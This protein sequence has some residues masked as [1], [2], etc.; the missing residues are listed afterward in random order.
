MKIIRVSN[1]ETSLI[2]IGLTR[3]LLFI[4]AVILFRFELVFPALLCILLLMIS[5]V[6]KWWSKKGLNKLIVSSFFIPKRIFAGDN[7]AFKVA[8][9][10]DKFLPAI[11]NWKIELPDCIKGQ[12]GVLNKDKNFLSFSAILRWYEKKEKT[13]NLEVS[14]RGYYQLNKFR[15]VSSDLIGISDYEALIEEDTSLIVYPPVFPISNYGIK[16][17]D[18]IGERMDNRYILPDPIMIMGLREYNSDMP[19]YL[20]DWKA[21]A[22]RDVFMA[23]LIEPSANY[24]ICVT[25]DVEG[26]VGLEDGEEIF[27]RALSI[28][29]SIAVW[30]DE[31]KIPIGLFINITQKGFPGPIVVPVNS[32]NSHMLLLLEKLARA[33][34]QLLGSWQDLLHLSKQE[35]PW[36]TTLIVIRADYV[37]MPD[38]VVI[39]A[40]P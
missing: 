16:P 13:F 8:L 38:V 17:R 4:G 18:L 39:P 3:V 30:A 29:A 31:E 7:V 36:G 40:R 19:A 20:I 22:K 5:I 2:T 1:Q 26:L 34:Y 32:G 6:S 27:E 21:S 33:E 12:E 11:I 35:I 15:L 9:E 37:Y 24:K 10:N 25:V 28:A 14:R 23:K